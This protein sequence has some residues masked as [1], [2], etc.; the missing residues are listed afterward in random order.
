MPPDVD[1]FGPMVSA[2]QNW[3]QQHYPDSLGTALYVWVDET[4]PPIRVTVPTL[5]G[6]QATPLY[7]P[8][9]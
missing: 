3:L 2:I 9:A 4:L 8:Q 5:D 6:E 7:C 1:A